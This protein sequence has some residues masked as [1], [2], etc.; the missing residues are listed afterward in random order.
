MKEYRW[1]F[2]NLAYNDILFVSSGGFE[3]DESEHQYGPKARTGYMFFYIVRGKGKYICNNQEYYLKAG[4]IF[5]VEP[6]HIVTFIADRNDPWSYYWIRFTGSFI[7]QLIR[8]VELSFRNPVLL[9]KETESISTLIVSMVYYGKNHEEDN[10]YLNSL[11]MQIF[12]LLEKK[13]KYEKANKLVG[14]PLFQRAKY[15][16][17]ENYANEITISDLIQELNIDRSYLYRLFVKNIGMGPQEYLLDC[18]LKKASE[19]LKSASGSILFVSKICGFPSYQSF[20]NH[21]KKKYKISP[22]KFRNKQKT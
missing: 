12:H 7:N 21:F 3:V 4:D 20:Y 13:Q 22:G 16:L 2:D 18:R 17:N 19:L 15:Y 8:K 14:Q 10:F 6:G 9:N 5:M 11:L 1:G